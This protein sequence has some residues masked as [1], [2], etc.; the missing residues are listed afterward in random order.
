MRVERV[1]AVVTEH[2]DG[3]FRHT[4]RRQFVSGLFIDERLIPTLTVNVKRAILYLDH[5]SRDSNNAL[6]QRLAV[7]LPVRKLRRT[8]QSKV[9]QG[10]VHLAD[11]RVDCAIL[12]LNVSH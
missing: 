12:Q 8:M 11:D 6:Y 1:V 9:R 2:K 7:W 5:V 3:A 10:R 4:L